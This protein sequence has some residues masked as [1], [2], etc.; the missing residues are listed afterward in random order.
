MCPYNYG[1]KTDVEK[2]QILQGKCIGL[3]CLNGTGTIIQ[4]VRA[5]T[6]TASGI[7]NLKFEI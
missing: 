1:L 5:L 4:A 2:L 6:T 7:S 3:G